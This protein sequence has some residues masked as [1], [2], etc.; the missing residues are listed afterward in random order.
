MCLMAGSQVDA[1]AHA[2]TN[3]TF[4]A[5][6]SQTGGNGVTY[7]PDIRSKSECKEYDPIIESFFRGLGN[8]GG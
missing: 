2:S 1:C 8:F 4:R 7:F 6:F 3:G 5:G